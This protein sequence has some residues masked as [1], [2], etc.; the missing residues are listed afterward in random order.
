MRPRLALLLALLASSSPGCRPGANAR[1]GDSHDIGPVF[2]SVDSSIHHTF[3]VKNTTGSDVYIKDENHSCSCTEV[4]YARGLLKAGE[5]TRLTMRVKV[6]PT[7]SDITVGCRLLTDHP[8]YTE[9]PFYLHIESFPAA[10][11]APARVELGEF[12]LGQSA[13]GGPPTAKAEAWLETYATEKA[14]AVHPVQV[15]AAEGVAV[16]LDP[17]PSR[18]VMAGG[19]RRAR[20]RL[21]LAVEAGSGRSVAGEQSRPVAVRLD[22]GSTVETIISWALVTPLEVTPPRLHFGSL[23]RGEP[24]RTQKVLVRTRDGRPFRILGVEAEPGIATALA[25]A[26]DSTSAQQLHVISLTLAT[27]AP[28]PSP[29]RSGVIRISTDATP[30]AVDVPWSVFFR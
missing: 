3:V 20:Y 5:T 24:S 9:W 4:D 16:E 12:D 1:P 29:A 13:S 22:D 27:S 23:G 21:A 11:I 30:V 18:D 10:R 6:H 25:S 26:A 7:Y 17:T 14:K 8:Q 15:V 19:V 2:A 28:E